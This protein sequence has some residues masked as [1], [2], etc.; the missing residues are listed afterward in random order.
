M[1][2]S[3]FQRFRPT[4]KLSLAISSLLNSVI[5]FI[6]SFVSSPLLLLSI[7]KS[8]ER[9][10]KCEGVTRRCRGLLDVS[11]RLDWLVVNRG[12]RVDGDLHSAHPEPVEPSRLKANPNSSLDEEGDDNGLVIPQPVDERLFKG[13]ADERFDIVLPRGVSTLVNRGDRMSPSVAM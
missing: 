3:S 10:E 1:S 12:F 9:V 8:K 11:T 6:P 7:S 4:I 5:P 13:V 2:L